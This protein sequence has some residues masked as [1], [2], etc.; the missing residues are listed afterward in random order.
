M[1]TITDNKISTQFKRV[2]IEIS[3]ICNLKCKF[4]SPLLREK[5]IMNIDEFTRIVNQIKPFSKFVYFH[6]KGEPL[7]HPHLSEFLDICQQ[8]D[9][10]VNITTNGTLLKKQGQLLLNHKAMRQVNIS[11]H[12]LSEHDCS[13]CGSKEDYIKTAVDFAKAANDNNI[14]VVLRLWNLNKNGE[15]DSFGGFAMQEIEKSFPQTVPLVEQMQE[16]LSGEKSV[17]IAKKVF[18]GWEKEFVWPSL[19]HDFVGDNGFC[20]G[21]RHQVGILCDGS[22]VPCCLDANG[23]AIL[24]NI[25]QSEFAEIINSKEAIKIRK[26]FENRIVHNQLCKRCTFRLHL[27]KNIENK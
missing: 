9:L 21:M 2:Y 22:V 24:G 12:S 20:Y 11:L 13:T 15:T 3:N 16:H 19:S 14:Y 7:M 25:Y 5:R 23:E 6:I 1:C 18:V 27:R 26:G 8:N 4:C 10:Q 17:K